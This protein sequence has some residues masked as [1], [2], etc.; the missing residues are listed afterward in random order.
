MGL[1]AVC[2]IVLVAIVATTP[3]VLGQE[4]L[5]PRE[6]HSC[7]ATSVVDNDMLHF[8]FIKEDGRTFVYL[9][10]KSPEAF[11][12]AVGGEECWTPNAR[13]PWHIHDRVDF[14]EFALGAESC[15]AVQTGGHWDPTLACGP[16]TGNSLC[17]SLGIPPS[18][19]LGTS[20]I[21]QCNPSIYGPSA[22][23]CEVGDLS[24]KYGELL[25]TT[26][27]NGYLPIALLVEDLHDT[28]PTCELAGK[29]IVLHCG[30]STVRALCAQLDVRLREEGAIEETLLAHKDEINAYVNYM[31]NLELQQ[32]Q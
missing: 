7:M 25:L 15:G 1:R 29:S 2:G 6:V 28:A 11:L 16:S 10:V 8:E 12:H 4:E 23:A 13:I 26:F 3:Y 31:R 20:G 5:E 21:Y 24:G 30:G 9:N 19:V 32:Q 17:T 18:S 22:Y 14:G 27:G